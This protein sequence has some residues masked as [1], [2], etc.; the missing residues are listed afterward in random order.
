MYPF[1]RILAATTC[2]GLFAGAASA[3]IIDGAITAGTAL[4]AGGTFI[5]LTV[6]FIESDPDSTVGDDNFQSPNLYAFDEVQNIAVE[7]TPI[8]FDVGPD[9]SAGSVAVGA[10][11][12]S[13]YIIF[14]PRQS[15]SLSGW[16]DFDSE[17]YGVVTETATFGPSDTLANPGV[18]YLSPAARG[19]ESETVTISGSRLYL[20]NW[21][22]SSPGD[23]V[24]VFTDRSPLADVPVPASLPLL[25]AGLGGLFGLRRLRA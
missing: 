8:P 23:V 5:K 19:L 1:A 24:R 7:D 21:T 2:L 22:A 20:N 3:T 6:P 11:V 13:H 18:T 15:L 14:D 10:V 16:V 17:I 9:G 4:S 12:A 25:L